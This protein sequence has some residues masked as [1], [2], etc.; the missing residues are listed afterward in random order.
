M[1]DLE[2]VRFN[3]ILDKG[4]FEH[5]KRPVCLH[6]HA[7]YEI[8]IIKSG[9][10]GYSIDGLEI[11]LSSGNCCIIGPNVY[12]SKGFAM[13]EGSFRYCFKFEWSNEN[14]KGSE[15]IEI[16]NMMNKVCILENCA[17]EVELI[18]SIASE[19]QNKQIGYMIGI[20][21][22]F[23][24][25]MLTILRDISGN[26][27]SVQMPLFKNKEEN[28]TDIIDVFFALNYMNDVHADDLAK[29]LNLS[30]RQLNRVILDCYGMTFKQKLS[31]IRVFA[32]KDLL[33]DTDMTILRIAETVGYNNISYF[34]LAFKKI[35]GTTPEQF[36][37]I[38]G[39]L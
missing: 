38:S 35:T 17:K 3:V 19:F 36:R 5:V 18:G 13:S 34:N 23:S 6:N 8:H 27:E 11:K 16:L 1:V 2:N 20:H 4:F 9:E 37:K 31:Q 29:L 30:I 10:Y 14:G 32:A 7:A 15:I 12:H 21:N 28:R 26:R 24:Q 22:L 33:A 39:T 25:L